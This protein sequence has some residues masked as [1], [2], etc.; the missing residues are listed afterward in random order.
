MVARLQVEHD[1]F[2][3]ESEKRLAA[4]AAEA[5]GLRAALDEAE[6]AAAAAAKAQRAAEARAG[7]AE[8]IARDRVANLTVR[9]EH[10]AAQ[11]L[12]GFAGL[13]C[14]DSRQQN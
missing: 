2:V 5:Q 7:Q 12:L 6:K 3:A 10:N 13:R 9:L 14:A 1:K 4:G 8:E 11:L